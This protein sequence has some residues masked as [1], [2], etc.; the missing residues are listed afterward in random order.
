MKAEAIARRRAGTAEGRRRIED[1]VA[2]RPPLA[3]LLYGLL[4][5]AMATGQ[6]ASLGT[7][8]EALG[9]YD[10]FGPAA[11]AVAVI[12]PLAELTVAAGF[13]FVPARR[14]AAV[15]GLAVALFWTAVAGQA[16]A[17]GIAVENCGCFGA[18]LAQELRWW[19]LLE[20]AEFL[21][22]AWWA[23]AR[24]GLPLPLPTLRIRRAGS[25]A[26]IRADA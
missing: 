17:R 26:A 19:V 7:F 3:S 9:G 21:L 12:V 20:D 4:L 14:A 18:Y 25:R 13:A 23:G 16:F 11:P 22:L 24:A 5:V 2:R 1:A 10:A 15:L 6:L 8:E